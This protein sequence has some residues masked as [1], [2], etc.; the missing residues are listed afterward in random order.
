MWY[1][2][3]SLTWKNGCHPFMH[4]RNKA[5]DIQRKWR[6]ALIHMGTEITNPTLDVSN[7]C[8]SF[9]AF[10]FSLKFIALVQFSLYILG[11]V[12]V[13]IQIALMDFLSCLCVLFWFGI[14][15]S[16]FFLLLH[17]NA[18]WHSIAKAKLCWS[19]NLS[20]L[21]LG[22]TGVS[23]YCLKR[24]ARSYFLFFFAVGTVNEKNHML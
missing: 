10:T 22:L 8:C 4:N 9:R 14:F 24:K 18:L 2:T 16:T 20:F 7:S 12:R 17:R 19:T 6:G 21:S 15:A 3:L 23:C 5:I 1:S 13:W 11:A